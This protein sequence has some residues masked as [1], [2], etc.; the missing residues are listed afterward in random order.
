M[1]D[2][3]QVGLRITELRK[4]AGLT[5]VRLAERLNIT[6]QAIS[7]WETGVSLP[8]AE[9]LVLLSKLFGVAIE[10]ILQG[11]AADE[12]SDSTPHEQSRATDM[13][14]LVSIASVV[15]RDTIGRL[16]LS[17][18]ATDTEMH[19]LHCLAPFVSSEALNHLVRNMRPENIREDE[20]QSLAA[21]L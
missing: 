9:Y 19:H 15:D 16:V 3:V 14:Q 6:H 13:D 18:D 4:N 8:D 20:L 2:L 5:Q 11:G 17:A 7:K 10:V 21:F 1:I 12:P